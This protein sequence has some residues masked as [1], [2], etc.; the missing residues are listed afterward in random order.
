MALL[1]AVYRPQTMAEAFDYLA[2]TDERLLPLAGGTRLV[3]QLETRALTGVDG[4]VDLRLLGLN[5]IAFDG[6]QLAI[7]AMTTLTDLL[8]HPIGGALA[9]GLLRLAAHGEGPLNLRNAATIGGVVALAETDSEV[10]AALLALGA[11]VTMHDG[12]RPATVPL[13]DL[14]TINGLITEVQLPVTEARGAL[15]RVARTPSDRPIVAAVAVRVAG[16]D[17][18]AL[19]GV[20]ARPVLIGAELN[21]P[22]DYR[23]SAEY[24][25]AMVDVLVARATTF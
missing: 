15:A 7:G 12:T 8:E 9:D 23:G 18:V 22:D 14:T 24:R 6:V 3:G 16:I 25:R 13:A 20:A 17:R 11:T 19:C 2:R 21:P 10:Y 4:V 5:R 1:Q